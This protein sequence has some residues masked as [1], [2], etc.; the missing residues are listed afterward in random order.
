MFHYSVLAISLSS[1]ARLYH[2]PR[3]KGTEAEIAVDLEVKWDHIIFDW[4]DTP[5]ENEEAE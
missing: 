5:L 3:L 1:Y 2:R 4:K